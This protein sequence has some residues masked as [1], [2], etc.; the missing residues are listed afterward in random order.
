[1]TRRNSYSIKRYR[2]IAGAAF[3][4]LY[5]V[6]CAGCSYYSLSGSLPP[7]IKTCAVPLFENETVEVDIVENITAE[8]IDAIISDGNMDVVSEFSADAIVNGTIVDIIEMPATYSKEEEAEQF[9]I[10]V[11]ANVQFFDR[12]K[13]EV[14]WEE[15]NMEG[16]ANFNAGDI[17]AREAGIREALEMLAKEIID[18]TVSGW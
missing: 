5:T 3:V 12:K 7:H 17:S 13:N 2:L 10:T 15:Q 16:W 1:M 4:A 18:K 6:M 9:K 14:I 8:V 11:Y